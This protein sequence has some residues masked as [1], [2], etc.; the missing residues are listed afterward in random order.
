MTYVTDTKRLL[1]SVQA[2]ITKIMNRIDTTLQQS[3]EDS[4]VNNHLHRNAVKLALLYFWICQCV[5]LY[6]FLYLFVSISL[7]ACV[8][9]SIYLSSLLVAI[10]LSILFFRLDQRIGSAIIN[11][12]KFGL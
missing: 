1:I 2:Y 12:Y 11:G 7:S 6:L 5:C 4:C 8:H 3:S 9:F 10:T